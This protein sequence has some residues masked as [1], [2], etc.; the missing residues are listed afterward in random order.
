[1]PSYSK[2]SSRKPLKN[3]DLQA[4][5]FSAIASAAYDQAEPYYQM[6]DDRPHTYRQH[7]NSHSSMTSSSSTGS[8]NS[9]WL[10][11]VKNW[12]ST[13]EPSAQAMKKQRRDTYKK[14]GVSRSDPHAA[15][16]MH[17]P[18]GKVPK[19]AITSTSGPTPEELI[20]KERKQR[21]EFMKHAQSAHSVSSGY[22]SGPNSLKETNP[23]APWDE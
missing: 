17:L 23:V 15:E 16:K 7:S 22:S 6:P 8:G 9:R 5:Y 20:M 4:D 3:Q 1:M 19:N 12:L 21:P 13:S 14:H 2:S 11:G 10:S 18:M